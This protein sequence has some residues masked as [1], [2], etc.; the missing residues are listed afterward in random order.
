M[1]SQSNVEFPRFANEE[2]YFFGI[3]LSEAA[4]IVGSM[5]MVVL[6]HKV[7]LSLVGG[8]VAWRAYKAYKDKGQANILFQLAYRSGAYVP[9]SHLFPEPGIDS[10]RS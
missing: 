7:V 5:F 1:K 8:F 4:I 10:F 9:K 3:T 6:T 2:M